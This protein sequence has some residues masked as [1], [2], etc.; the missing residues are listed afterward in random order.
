MWPH[1]LT[2]NNIC[3]SSPSNQ[4]FFRQKLM[5]TTRRVWVITYS[6]RGDAYVLTQCDTCTHTHVQHVYVH[7][8][9]TYYYYYTH[10]HVHVHILCKHTAD[11]WNHRYKKTQYIYVFHILVPLS[12]NNFT[13]QK[14]TIVNIW[15]NLQKRISQ[16]SNVIYSQ[17]R[18]WSYMENVLTTIMGI[19]IMLWPLPISRDHTLHI[20]SILVGHMQSCYV[21]YNNYDHCLYIRPHRISQSSD[22]N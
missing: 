20:H 16:I 9:S 11:F 2:S 10:V 4:S 3:W 5:L 6:Y 18:D 7:I 19:T 15:K 14:Y 13:I 1:A 22:D 17:C 8:H 21:W 12:Q